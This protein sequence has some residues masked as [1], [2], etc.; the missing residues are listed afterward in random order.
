MA[1]PQ[2]D[3]A[4]VITVRGQLRSPVVPPLSRWVYHVSSVRDRR[5]GPS[6]HMVGRAGTM[7]VAADKCVARAWPL[8]AGAVGTALLALSLAACGGTSS[9]VSVAHIGKAAPTTTVPPAVRSGGTPSLQQLYQ[10]VLAYAGCMRSHGD[11]SFSPPTTV[12]N[13]GEQVVG[14]RQ[15]GDL[16]G[17]P[18]ALSQYRSANR[19]CE[20]LLPNNGTGPSQTQVQQQLAKDLK[21]S[22]CMRSHGLPNFPDPKETS[23]EGISISSAHP[24]DLNSRQFQTAQNDCRSLVPFP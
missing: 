16:K 4:R 21:F 14:W 11:P 2:A 7:Q 18:Q 9:P 20:V 1:V 22:E 10:D 13:A 3:G 8:L 12:D 17:D 15:P 23:H 5:S 24:V 6:G 19:T